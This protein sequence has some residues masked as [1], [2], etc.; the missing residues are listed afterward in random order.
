MGPDEIAL[1]FDDVFSLVT[2]LVGMGQFGEQVLDALRPVDEQLQRMTDS[3]KEVW[4]ESAVRSASEWRELRILAKSAE[5]EIR[6]LFD[7]PL[8]GRSRPHEGPSV[9]S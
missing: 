5:D 9:E 3:R 8:G 1:E 2:G 7:E 4:L 6:R